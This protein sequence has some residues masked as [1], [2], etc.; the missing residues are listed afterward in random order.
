MGSN[1]CVGRVVT[2]ATH[3]SHGRTGMYAQGLSAAG[4]AQLNGHTGL[5]RSR[6]AQPNGLPA[7]LTLNPR[8]RES[9][10][11]RRKSINCRPT[12]RNRQAMRRQRTG[13]LLSPPRQLPTSRRT[14]C[15]SPNRTPRPLTRSTQRLIRCS[16][17]VRRSKRADVYPGVISQAPRGLRGLPI[18][19]HGL[20]AA[21]LSY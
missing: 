6:I 11:W 18:Y 19:A 2:G 16:K 9:R 8:K 3:V 10:L 4:N 21:L 20:E 12:S 15:R 5:G 7:V 17:D 14:L 1:A 13:R